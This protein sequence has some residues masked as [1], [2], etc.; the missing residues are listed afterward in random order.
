MHAQASDAFVVV[1]CLSTEMGE[2]RGE[3]LVVRIR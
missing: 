2:E 3:A 1:V